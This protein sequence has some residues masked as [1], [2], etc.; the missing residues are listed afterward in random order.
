[1]KTQVG[2]VQTAKGRELTYAI[3][4]NGL[5]PG[6]G[7]WAQLEKLLANVRDAD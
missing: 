2:F 6:R 5:S 7:Y 1:V 3:M 4:G